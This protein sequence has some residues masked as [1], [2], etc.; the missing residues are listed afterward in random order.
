MHHD[1]SS[2]SHLFSPWRS[3]KPTQSSTCILFLSC[4]WS[5]CVQCCRPTKQVGSNFF[6]FH[7]QFINVQSTICFFSLNYITKLFFRDVLIVVPP[8]QSCQHLESCGKGSCSYDCNQRGYDK[9][10]F[11]PYCAWHHHHRHV[12]CCCL[13][14]CIRPPPP[15]HQIP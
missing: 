12:E 1:T 14:L 11:L 5:S 13:K 3:A 6:L 10:H 15:P 8:R 4:S 7:L 2:K 9:S